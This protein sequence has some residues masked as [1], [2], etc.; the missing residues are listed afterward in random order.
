MRKI[1]R[2]RFG[3]VV[4]AEIEGD[5]GPGELGQMLRQYVFSTFPSAALLFEV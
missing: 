3:G 2:K 4:K 5:D 1:S